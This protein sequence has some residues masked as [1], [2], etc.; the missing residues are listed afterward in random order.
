[1]S[2]GILTT[3]LFTQISVVGHKST[4]KQKLTKNNYYQVANQV[5]NKQNVLNWIKEL[6]KVDLMIINMI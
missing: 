1:M 4:R 3:I 5:K 6:E 2:Y